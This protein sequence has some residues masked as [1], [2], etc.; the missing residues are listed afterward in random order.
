MLDH[1]ARLLWG[2]A[3]SSAYRTGCVAPAT[4]IVRGRLR[5]RASVRTSRLRRF[6]LFVALDPLSIVG[7]SLSWSL[8]D[9]PREL[10]AI[11]IASRKH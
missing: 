9:V 8:V 7:R 1:R 10:H 4:V 3:P 11:A 6:S 5:T 2:A